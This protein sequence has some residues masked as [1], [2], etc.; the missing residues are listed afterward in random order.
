MA[1]NSDDSESDRDTKEGENGPDVWDL[2]QY[3]YE[4]VAKH[5]CN[6]PDL[7]NAKLDYMIIFTAFP[8]V[9]S[10]PPCRCQ[11]VLIHL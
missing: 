8:Q 4:A 2:V 9:R 5:L 7:K 11:T 10:Y 6:D 1:N 3:G